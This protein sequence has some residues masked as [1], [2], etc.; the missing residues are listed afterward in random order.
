[1][2]SQIRIE[3]LSRPTEAQ[4]DALAGILV[5]AFNDSPFAI[6]ISGGD[7]TRK[8]AYYR[9]DEQAAQ[10]FDDFIVSLDQATLDACDE[11][12]KSGEPEYSIVSEQTKAKAWY[13]SNLAVTQTHRKKGIARAL[14][15]AG[16]VLVRNAQG[17]IIVEG[18]GDDMLR[19]YHRFGY[20]FVETVLDH[21]QL[22]HVLQKEIKA[23][24][25]ETANNLFRRVIAPLF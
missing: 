7:S 2:A 24:Y 3:H 20:T 14:I 9:S 22:Y 25:V 5:T 11:F 1:M 8:R 4:L 13:M 10:G 17:K 15:E 19:M 16:E 23:T 21:G 18:R 12:T 6:M